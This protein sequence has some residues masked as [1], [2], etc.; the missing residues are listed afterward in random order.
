MNKKIEL[1]TL[2]NTYFP[3]RECKNLNPY[4]IQHPCLVLDYYQHKESKKNIIV[5]VYGTSQKTDFPYDDEI[6]Y[7]YIKE[8]T[9]TNLDKTTKWI[10]NPENIAKIEEES[11]YFPKNK[12]NII[13]GKL[14]QDILDLIYKQIFKKPEFSN[15]IK[16]LAKS[17]TIMIDQNR[18]NDSS[19]NIVK[20]FH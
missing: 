11:N 4:P 14:P 12:K 3:T 1:G 15:L 18:W 5:L 8:D 13:R 20:T 7:N 10:F 2:I 6:I 9:I 16:E 17:K 19:L